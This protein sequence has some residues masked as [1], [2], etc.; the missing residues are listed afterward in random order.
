M[1]ASTVCPL[2]ARPPLGF[3]LG[4]A[5]SS[6]GHKVRS[7]D[8]LKGDATPYL[9][10]RGGMSRCKDSSAD[11]PVNKRDC[12]DSGDLGRGAQPRTSGIWMA[13]QLTAREPTR[14]RW[15]PRSRRARKCHQLSRRDYPD[16]RRCHR[17][18]VPRQQDATGPSRHDGFAASW[19]AAS[20][21]EMLTGRNGGRKSALLS[22]STA[23]PG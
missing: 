11:G 14:F 17:I 23:S 16:A 21:A 7:Q 12:V 13:T 1:L 2:V 19:P 20:T 8:T 5:R 9:R 10:S 22:R 18:L 3:R 6:P 15:Q 4:H